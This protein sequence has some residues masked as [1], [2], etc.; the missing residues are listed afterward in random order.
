MSTHLRP[1]KEYMIPSIAWRGFSD[2][3]INISTLKRN[4]K[5]WAISRYWMPRKFFAAK[6]R[7]RFYRHIIKRKKGQ[8]KLFKFKRKPRKYRYKSKIKAKY[9]KARLIR[10][11]FQDRIGQS[12]QD[13]MKNSLYFRLYN[14]RT[15][16]E[17]NPLI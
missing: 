7:A 17:I 3:D 16:R 13:I 10:R 1:V 11:Y 8:R 9:S 14:N 5:S 6:H 2:T 15:T 4:L 12:S